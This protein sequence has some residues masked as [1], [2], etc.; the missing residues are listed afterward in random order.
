MSNIQKKYPVRC[1]DCGQKQV[2]P[3][4][5]RH[6]LQKNHDGRLH[7]LVIERLP[8]DRCEACGEIYFNN[9]SDEAIS[10]ALRAALRL[11]TPAEI[12]ANIASLGIQQKRLAECLGVAAETLSRW[13]NG[14]MIQT[15]AMDNLLRAY[16]GCAEVRAKLTGADLDIEFGR[17]VT[18][19]PVAP[20]ETVDLVESAGR[21]PHSMLLGERLRRRHG[22]RSAEDIARV[23]CAHLDSAIP[24]RCTDCNEQCPRRGPKTDA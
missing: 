18:P 4:V 2:R 1:V 9:E 21:S 13:L 6:Q 17:H 12:R 24:S 5:I 22:Q 23:L 15:R 3:A 20:V 19:A 10:A 14:S 8:V 16:F 11:L 7:D